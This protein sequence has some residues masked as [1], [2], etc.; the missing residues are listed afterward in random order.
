MHQSSYAILPHMPSPAPLQRGMHYHIYN[1]GNNGET[2]FRA[3]ADYQH[4][5]KLYAHHIEPVAGTFAYCLMPNHFHFLIHVLDG[6]VAK[7]ASQAFSNLF[8]AYAKYAG[9]KYDRTGSVFEHP[10]HRIPI[11]DEAYFMRLVVYIHGNPQRHGFVTDFRDWTY[12]S[13]HTLIGSRRTRLKRAVV[14]KHF[15]S[16]EDF[17]QVHAQE[18]CLPVMPRLLTED[19]L[20]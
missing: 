7:S 3:D 6:E 19:F 18:I 4:F 16:A 17:Q 13:Y 10:F 2:L 15:G 5:L 1:R 8:N 9:R 12:S 14:M 20:V 11:A